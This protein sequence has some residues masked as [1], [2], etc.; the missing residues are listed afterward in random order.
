MPLS[1]GTRLGPYEILAPI[2]TGGMGEVYRARDVKL[3][4]EV[5]LKVLPDTLTHDPER[6]ARF[7]REAKVLA[8]LNHSN[9]GQIY[10]VEQDAL[11]MELI[12]GDT[13]HGPLP[14]DT[15]LNY[16]R[17]I[18]DALEAAHEKGI[19]HRD[20]KPANIMITPE[21]VVKV[22]DFG[23]AKSDDSAASSDPTL[24]PT[25]TMS[26]TRAG[27][28][29]G[30][31]AYMSPEQARG[32]KVDKRADIWAFGVVLFE[33]ITGQRLF[34]GEDLTEILASV[35]KEEPR[36]ELAPPQVRRLLRKCLEKDP[37]KR[38]RDIGDVW[39]LLEDG[40][41]DRAAPPPRFRWAP[42][43]VAGFL[44]ALS[45]VA[46]WGWLRPKP[47][48]PQPVVRLETPLPKSIGAGPGLAGGPV[49]SRD[50]SRLAFV[51]GPE[52][53]IYLRMLDQLDAR[54]IPGTEG[55]GFLCFSPNGQW[56][57]YNAGGE[58]R[59]I[60]IAGGP[61]QTL[62]EARTLVGPSTQS[63]GQDD[64]ILYANDGVIMRIPSSGG[65]P[66]TVATPDARKGELFYFGAQ[67]L[68]GSDQILFSMMGSSAAS[69]PKVVA[70]NPKTGEKKKLLDGLELA[71]Y[72]PSQADSQAGYLIF[73]DFNTATLMAVTFDVK[74][75]EV[76]STAV[77][78]LEGIRD[79]VG[80]FFL[81]GISDSGTLAYVPGASASN[82]TART[83]VW[84]DRKGVEQPLSAPPRAYSYPKISPDGERV[85]VEIQ[86]G[87]DPTV[88]S[89]DV[90][91]YDLVRGAL[92]RLTFQG[93][94]LLPLWTPDGKRLIYGSGPNPISASLVSG[95]ADG[96]AP[97]SPLPSDAIARLARSI[98]GD[99]KLL[100]GVGSRNT[101]GSGNEFW[102][103]SLAEGGKPRSFLN[104]RSVKSDPQ[105]SPDGRW[106]AYQSFESGRP[107][108]YVVPYP[109]GDQKFPISTDGGAIPRWSR[110]GREL[111]YWSGRKMMAVDIQ[112]NPVFRAGV[113]KMLFEG[114]YS[115]AGYDV[116]PDG[117]RF[118]LVKPPAVLQTPADQLIVVVNWLE[119]LR[120]RMPAG[121]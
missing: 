60:A 30:T 39:E 15:A 56:I 49:L 62:A 106:V 79:F 25:F 14:L 34:H 68:P 100:I 103:L 67:E 66:E 63:W 44:A 76:K 86:A 61:P 101:E 112:T 93:A 73:S 58:L 3:D 7:E 12:E 65:K 47:T 9:I 45:A 51:G 116:A 109:K 20:L 24:S 2:G 121:K 11:V 108:I 77:S 88:A 95:P 35:V 80:P 16:A 5:A 87:Q 72:L 22:L 27:L 38:L 110:N 53:L 83:L 99:G 105:I 17:Q 113:P 55:A 104:S 21:G 10:A 19:V 78:V 90:W 48:E 29:L 13:L 115:A 37:K 96:T 98:S 4:R 40:R 54:A 107:E 50:G 84:V 46:L 82:S 31:A 74:R 26:P 64:N 32:R 81:F 1:V 70:F 92:S 18:A 91:V 117:Q 85:A 6:L 57:S 59:K 71:Q 43:G 111:F 36:I 52:R 97:P 120:R 42:W 33:M 41:M 28:I 94:N 23:L 118:L 69:S 89:V 8:S 114:T 119:E 75:L 102:A